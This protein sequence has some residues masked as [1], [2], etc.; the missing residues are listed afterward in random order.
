MA[1]MVCQKLHHDLR[2]DRTMSPRDKFPEPGGPSEGILYV[3]G[4]AVG[5]LVLFRF[6]MIRMNEASAQQVRNR[7][8]Y[9]LCRT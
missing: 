4:C 5:L 9:F 2:G 8:I 7:R 3:N 6:I 1:R